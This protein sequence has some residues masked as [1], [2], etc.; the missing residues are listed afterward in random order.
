M[1][2]SEETGIPSS[3][4]QSM[5]RSSDQVDEEQLEDELNEE[6]RRRSAYE[7]Q[8]FGNVLKTGNAIIASILFPFQ[9]FNHSLIINNLTG[10][11]SKVS[12]AAQ[13]LEQV[14]KIDKGEQPQFATS[15]IQSVN[16][17]RST[18]SAPGVCRFG[19][20]AVV[21]TEILGNEI[22]HEG[23][24]QRKELEHLSELKEVLSELSRY[25][26]E[27]HFNFRKFMNFKSRISF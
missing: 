13:K 2:I 4:I 14:I 22:Y 11:A 1:E 23:I 18:T 17:P 10:P 16:P 9:F 25:V 20:Q 12:E 8:Q 5:V 26:T 6:A 7:I 27:L 24:P 19:N 21:T 3:S 15:T